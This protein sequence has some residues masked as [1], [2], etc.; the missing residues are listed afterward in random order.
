MKQFI[1]KATLFFIF[2]FAFPMQ[3]TE[4]CGPGNYFFKGYSFFKTN[5]V[6]KE[7]P[8]VDYFLRFD[9]L[10]NAYNSNRKKQQ[11]DNLTEWRGRFCDLVSMGDL[12]QIIYKASIDEMDLLKTAAKSKTI[13]LDYRLSKNS[14]AQHLKQNKCLETIDYLIFAKECEPHVTAIDEW[15]T[16]KRDSVGMMRLVK[17]GR[18]Q[19]LKTKSHYIRMRYAYQLIRLA[20]YAKN[21]KQALQL[22]DYLIPKFDKLDSIINYWILG[23]KAAALKALGQNVEAAYLYAQIFQ[24]CASKRKSAYLSFQIN[25]DEEWKALN[26]MCKDDSERAVLYALRAN[27]QESKAVEEMQKIYQLDPNN[28]NLEL[29]LVKEIRKLEKDFLGLEFND[30]ARQNKR[31]FNI[32]RKNAAEYLLRLHEFVKKV[33]SEEEIKD[34]AI[35]KIA[36]G[37][38]YLLE[39]DY[40]ESNNYFTKI[41]NQIQNDSLKEQLQVLQVALK[42]AAIEKIDEKTENE[43]GD[44]VREEPLYKKY[45]DFQDFLFDKMSYAY[46]DANQPGKAFRAQYPISDLGYNPKPE[47]VED[48]LKLC[49]KKNKTLLERAF[50]QDLAGKNITNYLLDLKATELF[51]K[52]QIEAALETYKKIPAAERALYQFNPFVET[53]NDCV[54]CEPVD[55]VLY[56]KAAIIER[57]IQLDYKGKADIE[58]G[59]EYF[60]E[61]GLAYYNMSYFGSSWQAMD[62]FR[63]SVN[64]YYV[65]DKNVYPLYGSPFGNKENVDLS[66][67]LFYFEKARLVA[68]NKEI[69]AK[70]AFMAARCEQNSYFFSK[71]CNYNIYKNKMPN[72]PPKYRKY[73]KILVEEYAD[74]KVYQQLI[75]ECK[76][77]AAYARK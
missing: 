52:F 45:S 71:D 53:I 46:L 8:Y 20:H 39:G 13:P 33:L 1:Y 56:D 40:Y 37:Y 4:A 12:K 48:L 58:K 28:D 70:A 43:L 55:T 72:P 9:D 49:N 38:L 35:W 64:W 60:F 21:Y 68:R 26:L 16:P 27:R 29:L 6:I 50:V 74:T 65:N 11:L 19:F 18:K 23:H 22:Y 44:I 54:N 67:A 63:S 7:S 32:P 76:Y 51:R 69:A 62:A 30:H 61:I 59:A 36:N 57:I 3:I 41:E 42:I 24:H 34:K 73:F 15:T 14:F 66:Q 77:F 5:L 10:Y 17:T 31:D 25:T 2:L 75:K 47:I